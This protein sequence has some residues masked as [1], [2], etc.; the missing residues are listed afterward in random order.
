MCSVTGGRC[1]PVS[2]RPGSK[3]WVRASSA[4]WEGLNGRWTNLLVRSPEGIRPGDSLSQNGVCYRLGQNLESARDFDQPGSIR[5]ARRWQPR[6]GGD[7]LHAGFDF[8]PTPWGRPSGFRGRQSIGA[9]FT[10]LTG[11][12]DP[13]RPAPVGSLDPW[14]SHLPGVGLFLS[15]PPEK[16]RF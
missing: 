12:G 7:D 10:A 2:W 14:P 3:L 13:D 15:W 9:K 16:T 5:R 4:S 6:G 11:S 1:K 8:E